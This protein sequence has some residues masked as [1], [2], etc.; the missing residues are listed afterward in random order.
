MLEVLDRESAE[1]LLVCGDIFDHQAPSQKT[2]ALYY[3]F[4]SR[5]GRT[6]CRH[7]VIIGGNH[8]S[9]AL[10]EAPGALLK[11]LNIHVIGKAADNPADEVLVLQNQKGQPELI[12]G[13]VPFLR[14]KDIREG[15]Y[16]E[17]L[18]E[19]EQKLREGIIDHYKSVC[20]FAQNLR[21]TLE[22]PVPFVAMGHLFA[23]G[24]TPYV[25]EEGE[26]GLYVGTLGMV[27][28]GSFAGDVDYLALGHIHRAQ[29]LGGNPR[30]RYCGAPVALSFDDARGNKQILMIHID[31]AHA[32]EAAR[33]AGGLIPLDI[34]PIQVPV[35][36]PMIQ[37][38]GDWQ[39][40]ESRLA[41]LKRANHQ[42]WVEVIYTG[43]D[44]MADLTERIQVLVKGS[45]LDVLRI[46][47]LA[48]T[49]PKWGFADAG[50]TL[51]EIKPEEVFLRALRDQSIPEN[52]RE[53]L[54]R[55]FLEALA[56]LAE[57]SD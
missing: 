2:Q 37:I 14:E 28:V 26:R 27:D 53:R 24:E 16:G 49:G 17:S 31:A 19:K 43:D 29:I 20:E 54:R 15:V 21:E 41:D 4:L 23:A 46:K 1:V 25:P 5:V 6:G 32:N 44:I 11:H 51:Q 7:V 36:Q 8:D 45:D 22:N 12:L 35:F 10:L 47:N 56:R 48:V 52:Q 3:Q 57:A 42:A 34:V 30:R 50:E 55:T 9:P 33:K 13:A 38:S 39:S 40:I 18:E